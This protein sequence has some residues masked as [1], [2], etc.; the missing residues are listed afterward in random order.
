VES[1]DA[2]ATPRAVSANLAMVERAEVSWV[3]STSSDCR[4]AAVQRIAKLVLRLRAIDCGCY[5]RAC[6]DD[7][8]RNQ[9][10]FH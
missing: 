3:S 2:S 1:R 10:G 9:L 5:H 4:H 8:R 7:G 6:V